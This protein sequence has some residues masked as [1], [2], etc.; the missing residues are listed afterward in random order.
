MPGIYPRTA[1]LA[2]TGATL[3]YVLELAGRGYNAF[4]NEDLLRGLNIYKGKITNRAVAQ[5]FGMPWTEG[6]GL[7]GL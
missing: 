4:T 2:L 7:F 6:R 1:T 5:A 3:P